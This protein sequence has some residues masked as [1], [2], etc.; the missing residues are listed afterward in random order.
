MLKNFTPGFHT[1][2]L[3]YPVAHSQRS[4]ETCWPM[5]P[6]TRSKQSSYMVSTKMSP[7]NVCLPLIGRVTAIRRA[8]SRLAFVDIV[9]DGHRVQTMCNVQRLDGENAASGFADLFRTFRRGDN[10]RT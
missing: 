5:S 9:Q 4:S 10:L 8:G 6:R 3:Q 1:Q 2:N 7:H